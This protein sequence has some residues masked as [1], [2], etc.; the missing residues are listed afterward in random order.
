MTPLTTAHQA[1]LSFT[2]SWSLLKLMSIE[3]W[4]H[5]TISSYVSP[6]PP[7]LSLSQNQGLFQW[8]SSSHQ[9]VK[10]L[11]LQLQRRSF[12]KIFRADFLS[13]SLI[14]ST[15]SPRDYQ[16]SSP[17]PQFESIDSLLLSRF[18]G[19]TLTTV[20]DYWKNHSLNTHAPISAWNV[21]K[22]SGLYHVNILVVLL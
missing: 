10:V 5:L 11:E 1:S 7:A 22:I 13:D 14:W 17:A 8:V 18:Y 12:Q 16:E 3:P 15:C 20:H 2:I 4:C 6:S 21:N 9:V 19:P